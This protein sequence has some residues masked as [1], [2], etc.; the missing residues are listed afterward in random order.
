MVKKYPLLRG[1]GRNNPK[2]RRKVRKQKFYE[3]DKR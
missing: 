2:I 3:R 1:K